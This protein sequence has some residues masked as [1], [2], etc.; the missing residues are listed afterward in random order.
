MDE[1]KNE[2]AGD[3]KNAAVWKITLIS[4]VI[5]ALIVSAAC[6]TVWQ[7]QKMRKTM[8]DATYDSMENILNMLG[9]LVTSTFAN[10]RQY[11][12]S[13]AS[14]LAI[15][16]DRQQWLNQVEYDRQRVQGIYFGDV[17][18]QT[19]IGRGGAELSLSGH[20]FVD[21]GEGQVRSGAFMTEYG[22]YAYIQREPVRQGKETVGYLYVLF[23]MTRYSELLPQRVTQ[24]NDIALMEAAT[25]TYIFIPSESASGLHLSYNS[26]K[27][28]LQDPEEAPEILA[29]VEDAMKNGQY[30]MR[31]LTLSRSENSTLIAKDYVM[32][33]WPVGDGEYY[34]SGFSRVDFLQGERISVE[35]A[36]STMLWILMGLCGV[37]F[38]LLFSI[39]LYVALANKRNAAVQRKHNQELNEA[40]SIANIANES[41]SNFLSNMSHD[42]RTPMNAIIGFTTLMD[43]EA[44]NPAKIR[45]YTKKLSS[46]GEYLL[47]LINDVLDMS[48]I[49]SGKTTLNI[50]S[51]CLEELV[52]EVE[53]IIRMQADTNRQDFQVHMVAIDHCWVMGDELRIR[54]IILNLLSNALKYTPSGGTISL[55]VQGLPQS[56]TNYQGLRIQVQDNGY[57]MEPVYLKTIF[58]PFTRLDNTMTGKI[59]G[60]GLGLA[61]TKNIVDL[62][63]GTIQ[64][65]SEPG[66]GS[67]FEVELTL[68]VAEKGP[69]TQARAGKKNVDTGTLRMD[70]LR[71]LAAE[72]NELNA[73]ILT[74]LLNVEGAACDI[75]PDGK[76]ALE[77]FEQCAPGTYDLILMDV[78]MPVMNGYEATRAIRACAHPEARTIPILAMTANAFASDVRDALDAGMDGHIAKPVDMAVLKQKISEVLKNKKE[79]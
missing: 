36:V 57:G 8:N 64:V 61:I 49:E 58:E 69:E 9:N 40:L 47:S 4:A 34:I 53:S 26:L 32:F 6:V 46:A 51:F 73:E 42:I 70:G 14:T 23:P 60:T 18:A 55:T 22:T 74:E 21:H 13:L 28:Y 39:F 35:S 66:K 65:T 10:D 19:A 24:G 79:V 33:L 71:I 68:P 27:Y 63:G 7:R 44:D 77:T 1:R 62:M 52:N 37:I 11:A 16:E 41:K 56:K 30:Y 38:A 72:D 29:E 67:T 78:Q 43:R 45:E 50:G 31:M 25:M 48:K 12:Q 75:R 54:Q 59:Q 17:D 2:R 5:V 20:E 15:A 3:R 76:A